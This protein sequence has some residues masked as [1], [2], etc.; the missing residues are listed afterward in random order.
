MDKVVEPHF[1]HAGPQLLDEGPG[2][3]LRGLLVLPDVASQVP[4]S[5]KLHHQVQP[6]AILQ[7]HMSQQVAM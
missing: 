7:P 5:T 2:H 6:V 1:L 4:P 3:R